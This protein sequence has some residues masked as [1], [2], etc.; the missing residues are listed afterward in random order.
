MPG[1][2]F[3]MYFYLKISGEFLVLW[4]TNFQMKESEINIDKCLASIA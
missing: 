2:E 3:R 4:K 1:F